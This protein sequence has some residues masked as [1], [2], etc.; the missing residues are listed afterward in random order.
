MRNGFTLEEQ[1]T[2]A[3]L[4]EQQAPA[5]LAYFYRQTSSWDDAE[6]L[7][8][9]VFLAV[10]EYERF[11]DFSERDQERWLWKVAHH[12]VADHFRRFK[13]QG[14]LP[15]HMEIVEAVIEDTALTPEKCLLRQETYADL[16]A[17]IR[18]LPRV[19]QD[20]L[21]LRFA[22]ELSIGQIAAVLEKKEGAIRMLLFRTLK[23]LR[24]LSEI[25]EVHR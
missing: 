6:D 24:A 4:Y 12:K 11:K 17:A 14:N 22:H 10:L 2:S 5:L 21:E 25:R 9:E 13:R 7:L 3:L 15:L 19:Q 1:N 20:V 8:V 16:Y 18:T 23:H